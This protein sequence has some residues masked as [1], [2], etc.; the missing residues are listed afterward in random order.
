[1]V[2]PVPTAKTSEAELPQT[3]LSQLAFPFLMAL[4]AETGGAVSVAVGVGADVGVMVT[5][6]V[7]VAVTE[8]VLLHELPD[9]IKV[10]NSAMI[11]ALHRTFLILLS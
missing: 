2:P 1:M 9:I 10:S 8:A 5:V 6:D 3:P 4:H 7:G 11:S